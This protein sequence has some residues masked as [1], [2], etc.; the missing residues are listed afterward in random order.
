MNT[1]MSTFLAIAFFL[2]FSIS[3]SAVVMVKPANVDTLTLTTSVFQ[4]EG[5]V[6]LEQSGKLKKEWKKNRVVKRMKRIVKR[7][8]KKNN[9]FG[10]VLEDRTFRIGAILLL[11]AI[12]GGLVANFLS[13]GGLIG[14]LSGI[15]ALVG[16][17]MMV[18]ALIE[19]S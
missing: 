18:W 3:A 5:P 8:F 10:S 7:F 6:A 14:W 16:L 2:Y 12:I 17:I 15:A 19:H 1:K 9:S 4:E 11:A 13:F